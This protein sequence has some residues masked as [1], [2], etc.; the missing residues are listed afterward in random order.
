MCKEIKI[1][2]ISKKRRALKKKDR[3]KLGIEIPN[4]V[5]HVL[6][7]DKENNNNVDL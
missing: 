2:R 1:R 3:I 7:L 5:R 6:L 4:N